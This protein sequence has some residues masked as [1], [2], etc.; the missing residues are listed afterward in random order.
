MQSLVTVSL[1]QINSSTW[2]SVVI[3]ASLILVFAV[4]FVT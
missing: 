1:S 2:F 3:N 4:S